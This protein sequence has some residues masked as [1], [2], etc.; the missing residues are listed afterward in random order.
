MKSPPSRRAASASGQSL[1]L[2]SLLASQPPRQWLWCSSTQLSAF[3]PEP[4]RT[5]PRF[6]GGPVVVWSKGAAAP[7]LS[8]FLAITPR[9]EWDDAAGPSLLHSAA[10]VHQAPD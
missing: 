1:A 6:G 3:R 8:G 7:G 9:G 4:A 2:L 10:D 5:R